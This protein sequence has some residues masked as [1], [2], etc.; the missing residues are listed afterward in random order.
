VTPEG[1]VKAQVK[2]VLARYGE[3]LDSQWYV[4][5]GMGSPAL[6]CIV[7][8]RGHH[9]E[10]ETKALGKLPT[11]RQLVTI[12]KKEKAGAKV[13]VIDGESGCVQ[14][15]IHLSCIRDRFTH[16]VPCDAE[17]GRNHIHSRF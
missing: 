17:P 10:I 1:K 15:E 4:P 13:F 14:L 12:A 11:P 9:I 5:N 16:E 8:Y 3:E 6:D 2:K 7:C